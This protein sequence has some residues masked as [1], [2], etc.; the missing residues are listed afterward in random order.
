MALR[1]AFHRLKSFAPKYRDHPTVNL[2]WDF[3][4]LDLNA[5]ELVLLPTSD[6]TFLFDPLAFAQLLNNSGPKL[7]DLLRKD[8]P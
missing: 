6:L 5:L 1:L 4:Y 7:V 3:G 2:K 8:N